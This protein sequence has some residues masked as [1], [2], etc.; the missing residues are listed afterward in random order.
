MLPNRRSR[1]GLQTKRKPRVLVIGTGGTIAGVA[2]AGAG[3]YDPGKLAVEA[4]LTA[5]P[6]LKQD[7][8]MVGRQL[9]RP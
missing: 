1:W 5:I 2:R 6:E 7:T 4:V 9:A 3:P 8:E